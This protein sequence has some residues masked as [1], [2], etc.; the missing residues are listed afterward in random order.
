MRKLITLMCVPLLAAP[1]W[2]LA[3]PIEFT[4]S[5]SGMMTTDSKALALLGLN[6]PAT[7]TS[8][9]YKLTL[10]AIVDPASPTFVDGSGTGFVLDPDAKVEVS[11]VLGTMTYHFIG[12]GRAT[13]STSAD[14]FKNVIM[15][16]PP[17]T[18]GALMDVENYAYI[19][20]HDFD[21]QPPLSPIPLN[22]VGPSTVP[23]SS[24][25]AYVSVE[26]QAGAN[27]MTGEGSTFSVM[28]VPEPAE[29]LMLGAGVFALALLRRRQGLPTVGRAAIRSRQA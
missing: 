12:P 20:G 28:A 26:T 8:L 10:V 19:P 25:S 29:Y 6:G 17:Q 9:P 7:P 24:F 1:L 27:V 22:E 3:D 13:V 11:L 15:F 16:S 4:S 2:A 18:L 21:A 14:G 5:T 23:G